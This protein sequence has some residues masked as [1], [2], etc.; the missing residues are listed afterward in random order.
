MDHELSLL[1]DTAVGVAPRFYGDG[2]RQVVSEA[3]SPM[4]AGA[5]PGPAAGLH[6]PL[7]PSLPRPAACRRVFSFSNLHA[8]EAL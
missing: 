2:S 7:R 4:C 8:M 5:Q 6:S 1:G 3:A